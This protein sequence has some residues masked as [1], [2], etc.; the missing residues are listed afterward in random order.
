[1]KPYEQR[2][3]DNGLLKVVFN[4]AVQRVLFLYVLP[5]FWF[6]GSNAHTPLANAVLALALIPVLLS[7]NYFTTRPQIPQNAKNNKGNNYSLNRKEIRIWWAKST[8]FIIAD[9][10][11]V[12][13]SIIWIVQKKEYQIFLLYS[14]MV[15]NVWLFSFNQWLNNSA[16]RQQTAKVIT[17]KSNLQTAAFGVFAVVVVVLWAEVAA[18]YTF[19]L[20]SSLFL[21]QIW[22]S[23]KTYNIF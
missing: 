1:M 19:S 9:V 16:A 3:F 17:L 13:G 14:L 11:L 6:K 12:L 21:I 5:W 4:N 18:F 10:L 15:I 20:L 22:R 2:F 8:F 7:S 23:K